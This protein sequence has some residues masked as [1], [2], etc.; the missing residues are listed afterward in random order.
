MPIN[1]IN[2]SLKH[3][4]MMWQA[5]FVRPYPTAVPI[6]PLSDRITGHGAAGPPPPPPPPAAAASPSLVRGRRRHVKLVHSTQPPNGHG[7]HSV[8]RH[9]GAH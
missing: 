5:V 3:W 7:P 1:S 4:R 9:A 8:R 2:E 6:P